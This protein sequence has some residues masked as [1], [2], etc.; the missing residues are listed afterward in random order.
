MYLVTIFVSKVFFASS[1][2]AMLYKFKRVLLII[3]CPNSLRI[4]LTARI[5]AF[6][7]SSIYLKSVNM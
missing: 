6:Y 3:I 1:L 7:V 2:I 5:F 4:I